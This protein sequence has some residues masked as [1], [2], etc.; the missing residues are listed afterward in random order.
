MSPSTASPC[1]PAGTPPPNTRDGARAGDTLLQARWTPRILVQA[2]ALTIAFI[3]LLPMLRQG[4]RVDAATEQLRPVTLRAA[5]PAPPAREPLRTETARAVTEPTRPP[6]PPS[7]PTR[8][9]L[10]PALAF[11]PSFGDVL[12][13]A[14]LSRPIQLMTPFPDGRSG[15]NAA[16]IPLTRLRPHYPAG[17]RLRGLEGHVRVEF[18]VATDGRTRDARIIEASPPDVFE[19]AT[20]RAIRDWRFRP[21]RRDGQPAAIRVTQTVRFTLEHD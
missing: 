8:S 21:P 5:I 15:L 19:Q 10:T 18:T 4:S 1:R 14:D 2:L 12:G 6:A 3:L 9:T 20:L 17:A 7:A 13:R 11:K 16:L